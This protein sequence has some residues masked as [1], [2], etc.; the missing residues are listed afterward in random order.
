MKRLWEKNTKLSQSIDHS[1][2][3][4]HYDEQKGDYVISMITKVTGTQGGGSYIVHEL[5]VVNASTA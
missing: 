5:G 4:I 3:R 2:L 1:A